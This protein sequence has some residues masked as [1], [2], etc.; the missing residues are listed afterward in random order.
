MATLQNK[1]EFP[2]EGGHSWPPL[3][4]RR[5]RSPIRKKSEFGTQKLMNLKSIS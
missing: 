2:W 4:T 5:M 1:V 3:A